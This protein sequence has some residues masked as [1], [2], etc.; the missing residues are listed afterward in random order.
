MRGLLLTTMLVSFVALAEDETINGVTWLYETSFKSGT[1]VIH[2]AEDGNGDSVSGA[3]TV[4]A[5]L[6][7]YR[8]TDL[9]KYSFEGYNGLTSV[10]IMSGVT[11]IGE[12]AFC[13]CTGL[14]SVKIPSSVTSIGAEAF[15]FCRSLRS[16]TI[17]SSV[18]LIGNR[19]FLGCSSL[20]SVVIPSSI[21]RVF[22]K[23]VHEDF[24]AWSP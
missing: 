9:D 4:P 2:R 12:W 5:S 17:P 3:I 19:A 16:L 7:G 23:I 11:N 24:F 13:N 15:C 6:G 21:F 18:T 14:T 20:R 10:E 8:V 22:G 1:A